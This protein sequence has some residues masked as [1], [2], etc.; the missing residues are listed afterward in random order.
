MGGYLAAGMLGSALGR[1]S[2]SWGSGGSDFGGG[3]G[4]GGGGSSDS[5]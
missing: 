4:F 5:W 3:G 2:G 1:S